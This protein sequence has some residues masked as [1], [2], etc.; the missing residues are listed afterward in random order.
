MEER[1]IS[2]GVS[3]AAPAHWE[4]RCLLALVAPASAGGSTATAPSIVIA[5]E[6]RRPG[7]D[8]EAHAWA[9]MLA[10]CRRKTNFS[11]RSTRETRVG[12]SPAFLVEVTSASDAG[13]VHQLCVYADAGEFVVTV[14]CSALESIDAALRAEFERV[15]A[16]VRFGEAPGAAPSLPPSSAARPRP[17]N[18][19]SAT[20]EPTTFTMPHIPVPRERWR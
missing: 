4:R 15:L 11:L 18:S 1:L 5:T 20:T 10:A 7:E 9:A 2:G 8:V 17:Q 6:P 3:L 16:S 12:G 14:T 13:P 19:F